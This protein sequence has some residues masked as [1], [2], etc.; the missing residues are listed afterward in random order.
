MT[1]TNPSTIS[2]ISRAELNVLAREIG[3]RQVA[4]PQVPWRH[5]VEGAGSRDERSEVRVKLPTRQDARPSG[6]QV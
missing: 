2:T 5:S 3:P 4:P 1:W 6:T